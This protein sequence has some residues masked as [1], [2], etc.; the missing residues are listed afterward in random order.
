VKLK[1]RR[2]L[3]QNWWWE[4]QDSESNRIGKRRSGSAEESDDWFVGV[5]KW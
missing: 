1:G 4:G 5:M 3:Q 2:R